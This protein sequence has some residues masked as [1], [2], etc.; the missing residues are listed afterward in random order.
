MDELK[1]L[2]DMVYELEVALDNKANKK[3]DD[4]VPIL[5]KIGKL[6][7]TEYIIQIGNLTIKPL[8]VEAYYNNSNFKDNSVHAANESNAKTYE[9]ARARQENNFGELYVHYGTKDG[10]DV[11]LSN[12]KY[13]LSFLI[14]N[15][16]INNK[17]AA[18]CKVSQ[19]LCGNCDY[20]DK[21]DKGINC[22]YYG[23]KIL[24]HSDNTDNSEIV[25]VK[26]KGLKNE[27]K[28]KLL[29]ALPIYKIKNYAFTSGECKTNIVKKYIES[30]LKTESY[31]EEKLKELASGLIAWKKLKG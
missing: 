3:P 11:V 5:Q 30:Q 22:K 1:K 7:L 26:R 24:M 8:L 15:A 20:I 28:N 10:I 23:T 19:I 16:L 29:A 2:E 6:L 25:F 14:K 9:L 13:Y 12:G 21:C 18:Q 4:I 17:F 27:Y 31:D